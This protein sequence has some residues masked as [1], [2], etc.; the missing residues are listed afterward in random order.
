MPFP[1][2]KQQ[3]CICSLGPRDLSFWFC[4]SS[5]IH[6]NTKNAYE[7]ICLLKV[8]GTFVACFASWEFPNLVVS[9]LVVCNFYAEA[10]FCALLRP[11]ALFCGLALALFC[12]HL[13]SFACFCVRPRL[14]RPRLGTADYLFFFFGIKRFSGRFHSAELQPQGFIAHKVCTLHNLKSKFHVPCGIWAL[15]WYLPCQARVHQAVTFA[16]A[17]EFC[18]ERPFIRKE[19]PQREQNF[20]NYIRK[21]IRRR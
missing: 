4:R 7:P 13:R 5:T 15:F 8:F 2:L 9:N 14:E 20:P 16:I 21:T 18:R 19:F 3:T 1:F 17:S 10:L 12:P 6:T 11:F